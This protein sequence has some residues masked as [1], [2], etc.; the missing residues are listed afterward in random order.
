MIVG[1]DIEWEKS[2]K[3]CARC[4]LEKSYNSFYKTTK[5]K[6]GLSSWCRDCT[7]NEHRQY[8]CRYPERNKKRHKKYY[9]ENIE[10][11]KDYRKKYRR[12][13]AEAISLDQRQRRLSRNYK[14]PLETYGRMWND[15]NGVC[16]ICKQPETK[17]IRG[18]LVP[19]SVDHDHKTGIVRALLCASCNPAI[20]LLHHNIDTAEAVVTYLKK[21]SYDNKL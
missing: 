6:T 10:T 11:I 5:G 14:L 21:W 19:L 3:R 9:D 20:G 15:Q 7:H 17:R 16:A 4:K 1:A 13:H 18:I 8:R 12:E 2:L